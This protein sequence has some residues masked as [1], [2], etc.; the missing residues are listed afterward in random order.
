[1]EMLQVDWHLKPSSVVQLLYFS[2]L[3]F[4]YVSDESTCVPV[5]GVAFI[6]RA[7]AEVNPSETTIVCEAMF[8]V[9]FYAIVS[10]MYHLLSAWC[11]PSHTA[12]GSN[13]HISIP[14][15]LRAWIQ[16]EQMLLA[17]HRRPRQLMACAAPPALHEDQVA[18]KHG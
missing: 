1:M 8:A 11:G 9:G 15:L 17:V 16:A 12:P 3:A 10:I 4:L 2:R 14:Q 6:F 5:R 7:I 13:D 18:G